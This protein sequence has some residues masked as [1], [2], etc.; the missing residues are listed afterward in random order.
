MYPSFVGA[1]ERTDELYR[2]AGAVP[3]SH[4]RWNDGVDVT[5]RPELWTDRDR[6]PH[7]GMSPIV[8]GRIRRDSDGLIV[9]Y[10]VN[11][12]SH[13]NAEAAARTLIPSGWTLTGIRT[14]R[15]IV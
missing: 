10:A 14:V 2:K 15:R 11:G 3:P 1:L 12:A 6:L 13:L 8:W 5:E 9:D 7:R 4:Q